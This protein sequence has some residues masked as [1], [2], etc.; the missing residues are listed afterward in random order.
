MDDRDGQFETLFADL[1]RNRLGLYRAISVGIVNSPAD[2]DDVVQAALV[3]AWNRRGTFRSDCAAL[4]GWVSRI[5]VTESYDLLR[6]RVRERKKLDGYEPEENAGDPA[7]EQL[8]R[9]VAELPE[10]YRETIHIA[11][12]SGLDGESAARELGCSPNTMYQR[13]HKAKRLL[14]EIM[15]RLEHE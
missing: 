12:L 14:K 10:L 2:A 1:I 15:G 9:A 5:V 3:K 6:R 13:V 4:S 7:L 8:D 11:V